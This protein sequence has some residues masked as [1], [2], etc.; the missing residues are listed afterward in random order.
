MP[1]TFR[2]RA[3]LTRSYD[4][5]L[6]DLKSRDE[7]LLHRKHV[8]ENDTDFDGLEPEE[9]FEVPLQR[10]QQ[11]EPLDLAKQKQAAKQLFLAPGQSPRP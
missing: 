4:T 10:K 11:H 6:G 5:L 8:G 7:D 3:Q 2:L 1:K 9:D